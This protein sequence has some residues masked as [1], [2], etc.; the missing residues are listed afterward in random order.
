[1]TDKPDFFVD[2]TEGRECVVNAFVSGGF[3]GSQHVIVLGTTQLGFNDAGEKR[4]Q[5]TVTV[6]LRFDNEMA[7]LLR[8]ALNNAINVLT[9]P[10]DVKA[11]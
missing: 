2:L 11:N 1:M 7:K 6:R 10:V 9:P 4:P 5:T 3:W 8:D